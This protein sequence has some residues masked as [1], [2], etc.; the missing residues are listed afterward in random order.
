M[1]RIAVVLSMMMVLAGCTK[2]ED[3]VD[4]SSVPALPIV[5]FR[6]PITIST[7]AE[8][9]NVKTIVA[10]FNGFTTSLDAFSSVRPTISGETFTWSLTESGL[11]IRLIAAKQAD[12][13][14]FWRLILNG[15]DNGSGQ[16][17]NNWTA[18]E[19]TVDAP[20]RNA[21]WFI[22]DDNLTTKSSDLI[23]TISSNGSVVGT[24]NKYAGGVMTAQTLLTDNANSTGE[25]RVIQNSLLR[26]RAIW[27]SSGNGQFWYYDASGQI[28]SQGTWS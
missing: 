8:A 7:H 12:E 14:F 13:G 27:L 9:Q 23:W 16:T 19:G 26:Y 6:G 17:Y 24:L 25:V 15:R 5:V 22:Y 18:F 20:G 4:L 2:E 28:T 10:E 3:P 21:T 1:T 11:T